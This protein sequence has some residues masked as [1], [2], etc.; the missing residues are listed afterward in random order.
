MNEPYNYREFPQDLDGATFAAFRDHLKPGDRAPDGD[1]VNA[2]TGET[3]RL[4][5]HWRAGPVVIEFGS[6]S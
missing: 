2:G 6:F 3:V 5:E 1:V 4:S